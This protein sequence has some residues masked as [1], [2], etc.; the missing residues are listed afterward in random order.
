MGQAKERNAMKDDKELRS[1]IT[2]E[3]LWDPAVDVTGLQVAV[4]NGV[5]TV[6]GQVGSFARNDAV[7]AVVHRIAG[8][9]GLVLQLEVKLA[10]DHRRSDEEL[11]E[12]ARLAL[13]WNSL[14][15]DDKVEVEVEDGWLTL[16]G[17]VEFDY[18]RVSAEQCLRPM[19]GICALDNKI[20]LRE[21]VDAGDIGI[22]VCAAL[23]RHARREAGR[24]AVEVEGGVVTLRG[25]VGSLPEHDAAI[26][27]ALA[28][29]GVSR[30]VD[31]LVVAG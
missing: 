9:R 7:A 18:Q 13:H 31:E 23:A 8:L 22:A 16:T 24:I 21:R 15:P 11:R 26:G 30:V 25:T 5:A 20:T 17:D 29:K 3:L 19:V 6:S 10:P 12:A 27:T 28:T 2:A 4:K 1:D 14:V